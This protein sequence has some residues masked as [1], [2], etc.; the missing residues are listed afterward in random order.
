MADNKETVKFCAYM[1]NGMPM[2]AIL[3][4]VESGLRVFKAEHSQENFHRL[5]AAYLLLQLKVEI[6]QKG[7]D[8]TIAES[9]GLVSDIDLVKSLKDKKTI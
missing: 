4:M 6:R 3:D 2:Y 7:I 8:K 9:T 5:S 1:A